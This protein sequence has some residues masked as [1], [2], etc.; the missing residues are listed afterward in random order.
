MLT[1]GLLLIPLCNGTIIAALRL[2]EVTRLLRA[3][4][5]LVDVDGDGTPSMSPYMFTVE[6]GVSCNRIVLIINM[7]LL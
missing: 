2:L 7:N 5:G 4:R 3:G 6:S 1:I